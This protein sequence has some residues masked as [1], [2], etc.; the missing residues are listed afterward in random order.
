M[1]VGIPEQYRPCVNMAHFIVV[2]EN[3][4]FDVVFS[5]LTECEA[6]RLCD[7]LQVIRMNTILASLQNPKILM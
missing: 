7:A 3:S 6:D 4:I 2:H 1:P 5:A